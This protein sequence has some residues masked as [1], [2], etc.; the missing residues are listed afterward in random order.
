MPHSRR[1]QRKQRDKLEIPAGIWAFLNDEEIAAGD[2]QTKY[3]I[4]TLEADDGAELRKLWR[5]VRGE[6][7]EKWIRQKP[8][9]RPRCW[10]RFEAP[11]ATLGNSQHL[12]Q[13][14]RRQISGAGRPSWETDRGASDLPWLECGLPQTWEGYDRTQPPV[15]ESQA[16]FLGRHELLRAPELRTLTAANFDAVEVL[17]LPRPQARDRLNRDFHE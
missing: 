10:W 2:S 9:T 14:M 7:L 12:V 4:H 8:G 6:L 16:A 15:W 17:E 11:R 1:R 13:A 5:R 3:L